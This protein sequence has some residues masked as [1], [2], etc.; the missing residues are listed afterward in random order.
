MSLFTSQLTIF[1][2]TIVG[3]LFGFAA[4][5]NVD[6]S[7][8]SNRDCTAKYS[9]CHISSPTCGGI[10]Q[11]IPGFQVDPKSG[12]CKRAV[13]LG[14]SCSSNDICIGENIECT[15]GGTCSCMFGFKRGLQGTDCVPNLMVRNFFYYFPAKKSFCFH[16][17]TLQINIFRLKRLEKLA[18]TLLSVTIPLFV[19]PTNVDV[20]K[21]INRLVNIHVQFDKSMIRALPM[22]IANKLL[23]QSVLED[24]AIA[25]LAIEPFSTKKMLPVRVTLV[26]EPEI[27][28]RLKAVLATPTLPKAH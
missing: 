6:E 19:C 3:A 15:G 17:L 13:Y 2:L 16:H 21:V 28:K 7:C 24:V 1:T 23:I 25:A 26:L 27:L 11:C 4:T 22:P 5:A 20:T 14:G 9:L 12:D 18:T 10:C 8:T